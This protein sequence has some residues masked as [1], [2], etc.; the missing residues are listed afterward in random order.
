MMHAVAHRAQEFLATIRRR[1]AWIEIGP[2][3]YAAHKISEQ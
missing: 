2:T 1:S 3:G